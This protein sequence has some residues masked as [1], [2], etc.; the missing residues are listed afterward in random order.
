MYANNLLYIL[1]L[2]LS[3][4]SLLSLVWRLSVERLHVVVSK[5][6]FLFTCVAAVASVLLVA[7]ACDFKRPWE[8]EI[9]GRG[10][11]VGV[12]AGHYELNG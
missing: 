11:L 12:S 5:W 2:F 9:D 3:K 1:A 8:Q 7:L 6:A 4:L 10:S